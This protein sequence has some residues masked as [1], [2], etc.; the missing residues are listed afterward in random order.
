MHTYEVTFNIVGPSGLRE[1]NG[2]WLTTRVQAFDY[3]RAQ[4][5]VQGQYGPN[6]EILSCYQID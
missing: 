3:F 5:M 2:Q 6:T 1:S 4:A